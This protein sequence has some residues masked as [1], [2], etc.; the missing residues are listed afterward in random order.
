MTVEGLLST[1][2]EHINAQ[3][4]HAKSMQK[5]RTLGF[6]P[7][8]FLLEGSSALNQD[9]MFSLCR[10]RMALGFHLVMI[11]DYFTLKVV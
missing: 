7:K 9:L 11:A 6:V 2:R 4:E 10:V 1:R 3:G 8:T 5:D